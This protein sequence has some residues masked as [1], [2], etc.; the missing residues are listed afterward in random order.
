[1]PW[2][3]CLPDEI[4]Q[5]QGCF[6]NV[7]EISP[8]PPV[9]SSAFQTNSPRFSSPVPSAF[10]PRP[11]PPPLT[12]PCPG[13]CP[14]CGVAPTVERRRSPSRPP[15]APS[16]LRYLPSLPSAASPLFPPLPLRLGP[17]LLLH[18]WCWWSY[19][20][21]RCTTSTR[22]RLAGTS[23]SSRVAATTTTSS[24]T[25]SSRYLLSF[26]FG[27]VVWSWV[28]NEWVLFLCLLRISLCKV[29]I[30]LEPAEVAS[31]YMGE[32]SVHYPWF[33]L[34]STTMLFAQLILDA[35]LQQQ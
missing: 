8:R 22:P 7:R 21:R 12:L 4:A 14:A 28:L 24:S 15:W 25:A 35:S 33:I 29:G 23:S 6:C 18:G 34:E 20:I 16:L 9:L 32:Q 17:S 3:R 30:L 31:P 10:H 13:P 27:C 19:S 5:L 1:M 26:F 11:P 2:N